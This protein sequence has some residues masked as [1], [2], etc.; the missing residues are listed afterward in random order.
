MPGQP[1]QAGWRNVI[2]LR[3]PRS[4]GFAVQPAAL[5]AGHAGSS[6]ICNLRPC[7]H[8]GA[9]KDNKTLLILVHL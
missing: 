9:W 6:H 2:V 8:S 1:A 5:A 3:Q 7:L 4:R